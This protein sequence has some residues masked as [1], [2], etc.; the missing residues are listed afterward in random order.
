M[1]QNTMSLFILFIY[2]LSVEYI[3]HF[4]DYGETILVFVAVMFSNT[5]EFTYFT[6]YFCL[7]RRREEYK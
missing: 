6:V 3:S 7:K 2:L 5:V 4:D 1:K